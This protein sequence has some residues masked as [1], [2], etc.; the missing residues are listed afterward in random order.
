[1]EIPKKRVDYFPE[2]AVHISDNN[3]APHIRNPKHCLITQTILK[4]KSQ[5]TLKR[6]RAQEQLSLPSGS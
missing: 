5:G 1:Y 2:S 4:K 3:G 6:N